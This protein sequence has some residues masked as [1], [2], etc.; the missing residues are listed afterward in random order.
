[1]VLIQ[2]IFDRKTLHLRFSREFVLKSIKTIL[3][4]NGCTFN[5]KFTNK[6]VGQPCLHQYTQL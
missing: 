5:K 6:E 4:I 3:E 1:M 2:L